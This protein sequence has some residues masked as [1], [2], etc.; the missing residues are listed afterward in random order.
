MT[1]SDFVPT[2][3]GGLG[4]PEPSTW[5]MTIAG[6]ATLGLFKGRRLAAALKTARS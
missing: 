2:D 3:G 6:L 1:I 4:T 5:I